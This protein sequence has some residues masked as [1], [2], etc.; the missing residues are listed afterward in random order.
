THGRVLAST[1]LF[2]PGILRAAI[3]TS[4]ATTGYVRWGDWLP[5]LALILVGI[6]FLAPR[7]RSHPHP[8]TAPLPASPR[9]LVV[10]PP[11]TEREPS[12]CGVVEGSEHV[13]E[14][15]AR[16]R[17]PRCDQRVPRLPPGAGGGALA[18]TVRRLRIRFP[19]RGRDA[20]RPGELRRGR[21]SHHVPGT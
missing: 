6:L 13:R 14:V 15:H 5:I 16:A 11:F 3:R 18:N 7:R 10:L 2:Q 1:G 4:T 9:V 12:P 20:C 8:P 21:G 17:E 19:E